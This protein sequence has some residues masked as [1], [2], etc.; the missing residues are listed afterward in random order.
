MELLFALP[1]HL[2]DAHFGKPNLHFGGN[3]QNETHLSFFLQ[4]Y[5]LKAIIIDDEE[6][7]RITLNALLEEFVPELQVLE[8]AGNVPDGVLAINKH[9][10][11]LVFLDIEMPE[12]NGFELLNF[13][14]EIDFEIIFV[15]AYSQYAIR[16]FEV[17]AVDYL[18]KPVEIEGLKAAINKAKLK[19]SQSNLI[20]RLDLMKRTYSGEEVRKIALPMSDGL[21]FV[22][23]SE[24][25]L[26][27][28][29][30]SYSHVFLS[31]GSKLTV[32]KPMRNFEDIL[33]NRPFFFR[34]HRSYLVNINYV[35]KYSRGEAILTM[36]NQI[37]V[38]ISR[39]R[40]Q[41]FETLL[42]K[43]RLTI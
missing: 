33:D 4:N 7:A 36:D 14:R 10:P 17:S 29:D 31:N 18:L 13:Y 30:R 25:V 12:Y 28:A 32:S 26:F 34:P 1:F 22:D 41:D 23:I 40:K 16:A 43:L 38:S 3:S 39:D 6:G 8:Q 27:E 11:D 21:V 20:Q 5:M 19:R 15:T 35:K 42:K 37:N 24:I 2:T 9:Q